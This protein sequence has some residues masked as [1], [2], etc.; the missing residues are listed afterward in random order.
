[1]DQTIQSIL[2]IAKQLGPVIEGLTG[3]S[4][5]TPAINAGK[6]VIELI[7]GIKDTAGASQEELQSTR[8]ELETR[9]NAH[10]DATVNRLRGE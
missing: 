3:T 8:D 6:A 1:M 10:V 4:L 7:D 5:I 2:N 9:V